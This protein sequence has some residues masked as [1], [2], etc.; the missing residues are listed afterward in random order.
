M[1]HSI[2]AL[3]QRPS[4]LLCDSNG[5]AAGCPQALGSWL[6]GRVYHY[7]GGCRQQDI[8]TAEICLAL[9]RGGQETSLV[10]LGISSLGHEEEML[11]GSKMPLLPTHL[12]CLLLSGARVP[13]LHVPC[14]CGPHAWR[15]NAESMVWLQ[16]S[17]RVRR[18][19]VRQ[20]PLKP[21]ASTV[22][23]KLADKWK[24]MNKFVKKK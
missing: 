7:P 16:Q 3:T 18:M 19:H 20:S 24:I 12:W 2:S 15:K 10:S 21:G 5:L 14:Q 11:A 17:Q 23:G 9:A 22:G 6:R 4:S 8:L 1:K 13:V